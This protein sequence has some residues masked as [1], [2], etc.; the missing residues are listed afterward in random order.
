MKADQ[1]VLEH[2]TPAENARLLERAHEAELGDAVGFQ[3]VQAGA[4]EDDLA[5]SRREITGDRIERRRLAGAVGA[6]EGENLRIPHLEAQVV[7]GE[8]AAVGAQ[9]PLCE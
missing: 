2:A 1:D 3:A 9:P 5:Y 8:E 4:A 6:D 7:D